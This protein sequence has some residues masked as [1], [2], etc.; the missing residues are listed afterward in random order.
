MSS[1][2]KTNMSSIEPNVS[3]LM[4]VDPQTNL[5]FFQ[6]ALQSIV[7]DQTLRPRQLV[8]VVDGPSCDTLKTQIDN[9]RD[10]VQLSVIHNAERLGLARCLNIGLEQCEY[11]LVARMDADD[12]SCRERLERQVQRFIDDERLD[13]LSSWAEVID[14]YDETIGLRRLPLH[15]S[16]IIAALWRCPLVHPAIMY[17]KTKIL[18]I[19]GYTGDLFRRQDYELWFRCAESGMRF[20]NLNEILLRY[21]QVS[22]H[23]SKDNWRL[24]FQQVAIGIRGQF[25]L[26]GLTWKVLL[27]LSALGLS[28]LPSKLYRLARKYS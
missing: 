20:G 10:M 9:L 7:I 17:R 13:I 14:E 1:A 23:R 5:L 6:R 12:I 24:K 22:G 18:G 21:R 28:I 16:D 15:H 4:A 2:G 27:P 26:E 25:R 3:V 19:G 11:E 8:L